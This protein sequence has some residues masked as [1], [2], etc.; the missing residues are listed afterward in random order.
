MNF[1]LSQALIE[2]LKAPENAHSKVW[3]DDEI[4]G[5]GVRITEADDTAELI[6][7]NGSS[8]A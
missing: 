7:T 4:A 6:W 3:Y 8:L 5:F 1:H 2:A